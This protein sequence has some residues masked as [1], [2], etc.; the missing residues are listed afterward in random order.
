[1]PLR[2]LT[3]ILVVFG[4]IPFMWKRPFLGLLMWVWLSIMNPHRQTYGIA[5]AM[6][7]AQIVAIVTLLSCLVHS[8]ALYR[9]PLNG[10]TIS[11]LCFV[12]WVGVSPLAASNPEAE[13]ELWMR[14]VKIQVMVLIAFFLVGNR[15]E[16][17]K[18]AAVLALSIGFYGVKGGIF[19][20]AT[21]G[22]FKVWGP[23]GTFI[24]DNNSVA[25]A[26]VMAIPLFR[27]LQLNSTQRAVRLGCVAAMVLCSVSAIG[28][29][30]RGALI[31]LVGM[32][33]FLWLKGRNKVVIGLL[34]LLALPVIFT[35]MPDQWVARMGTIRTYEEDG[36]AMGRVN[37]WWMAF[38]LATSRVPI[39]GGFN[40][41]TPEFFARFSPNPEDVHAA[42]SIYFQILGEHGFMGLLLFLTIFG[43]AWRS[44]SQV[45]SRTRGRPELSWARDLASMAQ[46]S[47]IGYALGGA[48]LS[49]T[50][51]D[52][53]YYVVVLLV[54][55]RQVVRGTVAKPVRQSAGGAA[56]L[57]T[58]T[59]AGAV[60]ARR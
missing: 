37:A 4:S 24:T 6:P 59:G 49:L 50:Y 43:L 12:L 22:S 13:I 28:S 36:S 46:V 51:F 45:I 38:N 25:L 31:A 42:H 55:L 16:L 18:L 54:T 47:L 33:C 19:T 5:Y 27:Y 14:V 3:L 60:E 44:G 39:G 35:L 11:L 8:K 34:L 53:P 20:L 41:Y 1:M 23:D 7:F 15:D 52:Y 29:Y 9:F 17:H 40:I 26:I 30:S 48:F 57:G 58:G 32:G 10:V 21:G 2:D 56:A